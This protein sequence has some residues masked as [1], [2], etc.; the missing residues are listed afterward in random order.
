MIIAICALCEKIL[1]GSKPVRQIQGQPPPKIVSMSPFC[2]KICESL[3]LKVNQRKELAKKHNSK[4]NG[5]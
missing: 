4:T 1:H 5:T 3:N 2:S